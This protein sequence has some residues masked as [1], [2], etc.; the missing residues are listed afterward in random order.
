MIK[1]KC[2]CGNS[3]ISFDK[4]NKPREVILCQCK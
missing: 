2:G 4:R 1:C 3:I